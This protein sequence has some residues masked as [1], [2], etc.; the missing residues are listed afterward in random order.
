MKCH[1]SAF[2]FIKFC[3]NDVFWLALV[4]FP[5]RSGAP[6]WRSGMIKTYQWGVMMTITPHLLGSILMWNKENFAFSSN[7]ASDESDAK[8]EMC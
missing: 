7:S 8:L 1:E 5:Q 3:I 4:Y 6:H 2:A